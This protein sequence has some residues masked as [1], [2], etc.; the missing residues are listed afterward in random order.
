MVSITNANKVKPRS[1]MKSRTFQANKIP[2]MASETT[3]GQRKFRLRLSQEA[4]RHAMIG[5][6]PIRKTSKRKSGTV[7]ELK[8]GAPTLTWTP[9]I[10]SESKGKMVPRKMV[11]RAETKTILFSKNADSRLT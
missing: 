7:T 9:A 1:G 10:A 6:I 5:P 2:A 4:R 11:K 3:A 8:Y